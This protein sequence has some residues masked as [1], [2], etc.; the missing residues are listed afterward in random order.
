LL[1]A[2][3]PVKVLKKSKQDTHMLHASG[4]D[5]GVG[6]QPKVPDALK[7][8]TTS[9]N[10]GTVMMKKKKQDDEFIH[11]PD[12]YVLTDDEKNDES[13]EFDEKEYEE[14]YG[15]VTISLKDT[16]PT[17]KEKGYVE[18]TVA[19]QVNINQEGACN[20][21]K[22]DAQATQKTEGP[23]LSSSISSDY[24]AKYLNFENIPPIN[25]EVVSILEL[26]FNMKFHQEP[27]ETITS[28]DNIALTEIDQKTTL[29]K[30]MTKS[31][32]FNKSLNQRALYHALMESI[33][34]DEDAMDEEVANKLKKR[35]HDNADKDEGPSAGSD[36]G[37]QR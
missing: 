11:T 28:S 29:F 20:Q 27:K 12:D 1:E 25:T 19:G 26:M 30:I 22:D 23:I 4:L 13:K 8:N 3:Q 18:I 5:D 2:T 16:E 10:E 9:I 6:S 32:S 24:A 37:L 14:L 7:E 36:R 35:K 17:D 33:L 34:E 21:V 31:K 15:D